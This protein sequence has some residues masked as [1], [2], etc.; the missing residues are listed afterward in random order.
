[1]AYDPSRIPV[2]AVAPYE[3]VYRLRSVSF[4]LS[5]ATSAKFVYRRA[6]GQGTTGEWPA[7]IRNKQPRSIELVYVF[8]A[9]DLPSPDEIIFEGRVLTSLGPG[10]I[11]GT[12]KTLIVVEH[13]ARSITV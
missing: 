7:T 5:K 10:E 2:N 8:R 13:P 3:L 9:G 4:D 1:M 6:K 11:I 12:T